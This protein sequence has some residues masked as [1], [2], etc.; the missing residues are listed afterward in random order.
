VSSAHLV[1]V[2]C[3]SLVELLALAQVMVLVSVLVPVL[4]P[5]L[6][7]LAGPLLL[8]LVLHS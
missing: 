8:V 1:V 5:V 2:F 3:P 7:L 4:P 6:A